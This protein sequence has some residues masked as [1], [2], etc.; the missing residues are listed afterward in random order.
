MQTVPE[1]TIDQV[2]EALEA[3][4]LSI[5]TLVSDLSEQ[6]PALTAY[7]F[8]DTFQ[9][10]TE[11]ERELLLYLALIV[12]RSIE[13]VAPNRPLVE[14]EDI[15]EFEENNWTV[16]GESQAKRFRERLDPFFADT[17]QED[18]LAFVEDA[19]TVDEQEELDTAE[20][21]LTKEGREPLFIG[22]KTLIDCLTA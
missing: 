18:L 19:L 22:L 8:S 5:E 9:I 6:Q 21:S 12:W 20:L 10:L 14:P 11:P 15:E 1:R 4:T 17:K 7:L 2:V 13:E 16:M 3:E